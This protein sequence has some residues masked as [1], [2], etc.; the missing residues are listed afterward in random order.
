M[1]FRF[2][3]RLSIVRG[4]LLNFSKSGVSPSIGHRAAWYTVGSRGQRA[5]V[6][7]P[8]TGIFW[9][10]RIGKQHAARRPS[11]NGGPTDPGNHEVPPAARPHAGIDRRSSCSF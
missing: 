9:I 3:R 11:G 6:G 10:G 7:L 2:S 5:T 8:G 1:P 4:L